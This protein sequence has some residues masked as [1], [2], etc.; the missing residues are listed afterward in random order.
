MTIRS[1]VVVFGSLAPSDKLYWVSGANETWN[2]T[3]VVPYLNS[4]F[5][6]EIVNRYPDKVRKTFR[7]CN[8]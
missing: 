7:N 5:T 2:G 8:I 6:I 3:G 4:G 1:V